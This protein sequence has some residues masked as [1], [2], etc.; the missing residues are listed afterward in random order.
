MYRAVDTQS[1]E[2]VAIKSFKL[3]KRETPGERQ[4]REEGDPTAQNTP[5]LCKKELGVL[6]LLA[7]HGHAHVAQLVGEIDTRRAFHAV[8]E[9]CSGGSLQ[10]ALTKVGGTG[11]GLPEAEAAPLMAQAAGALAHMHGLGVVHRDVKPGNIL[12]VDAAR[13]RVKLCDF[14]FA[15][16]VRRIGRRQGRA[17]GRSAARRRTSRP[18]C[19]RRAPTATTGRPSTPGPS[20]SCCTRCCTAARHLTPI[21]SS[22][23]ATASRAP[24]GRVSTALTAPARDLIRALIV[25]A[26]RPPPLRPGGRRPAMARV[27]PVTP[28]RRR[29]G[30][31]RGEAAI[32]IDVEATPARSGGSRK[33]GRRR[34]YGGGGGRRRGEHG[35]TAHD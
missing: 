20:V 11:R 2:E 3:G 14:G 8:L 18:S 23:C 26:A 1:R 5:D 33:R 15:A 32:R 31:R 7:A 22:N 24:F 19:A 9:Y 28:P 34:G 12:F 4:L 13:K 30:R 29:R 17:A 16:Q 21:R 6:R 25:Y 10:H 35:L 27:R